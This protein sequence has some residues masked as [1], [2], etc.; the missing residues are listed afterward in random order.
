MEIRSQ[1][2]DTMT[3]VF[4]QENKTKQKPEGP[5][6]DKNSRELKELKDCRGAA[7]RAD[8]LPGVSPHWEIDIPSNSDRISTTSVHKEHANRFPKSR[9]DIA[10]CSGY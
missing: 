2:S 8:T 1:G 5:N 6:I 7:G 3:C 10:E 4:L 9:S